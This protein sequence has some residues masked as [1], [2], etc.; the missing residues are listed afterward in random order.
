VTNT[1][2]PTPAHPRTRFTDSRGRT[3]FAR[4]AP[5]DLPALA[6]AGLDTTGPG[7]FALSL[8]DHF[9]RAAV[10][11]TGAVARHAP[12]ADPRELADFIDGRAAAGLVSAVCHAF[13]LLHSP[14][15]TWTDHDTLAGLVADATAARARAVRA[16]HRRFLAGRDGGFFQ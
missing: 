12:G 10:A 6:A 8:A 9:A 3:W 7:A 1:D 2:I 15:A 13:L 4:L 14:G 16:E 5:S 11:V